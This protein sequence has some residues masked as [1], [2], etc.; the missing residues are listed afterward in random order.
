VQP[1]SISD[2]EFAEVRRWLR[3]VSGIHLSDQKKQLVV[4]RLSKRL[5]ATGCLNF[6][7]YMRLVQTGADPEE[8]QSAIDLL[9][10]NETSFFREPKHFEHLRAK[11]RQH[12]RGR[13]FRVWSAAS[14]TGEEAYT[15]AMV[16]AEEL[17]ES[18]WEIFAS[19]LSLRVLE[20]ARAGLYP[21]ERTAQ[22][23]RELLQRYC[24]KG[25]GP[26]EGHFLVHRSLR[27]RVNFE[28]LNLMNPLPEVGTFDVIFL[29]NVLIYFELETKREVVT[30]LARQLAP[31][32]LFF[33]GHSETLNGVYAELA[34][35]APT[36]FKRAA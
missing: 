31:E 28:Q 29:R 27:S 22:I 34:P 24:L 35:V 1:V 9:T 10:T 14:S 11:L 25:T 32:G 7:D 36:V 6:G 5:G 15:T 19:D 2:R 21:M 17:G 12:P 30:R 16:L 20:H 33:I 8:R 23:P 18:P 26:Y 4:G 13:K 3:Q